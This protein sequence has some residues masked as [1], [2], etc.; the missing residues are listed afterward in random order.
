MSI[1]AVLTLGI[2]Y[3]KE[4]KH[5]LQFN[6]QMLN[7]KWVNIWSGV[8]AMPV[9]GSNNF[10]FLNELEIGTCKF[11]TACDQHCNKT[12]PSLG[13]EASSPGTS[14]QVN[15]QLRHMTHIWDQCLEPQQHIILRRSIGQVNHQGSLPRLAHYYGVL[16]IQQEQDAAGQG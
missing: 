13:P 14:R 11:D 16:C 4:A 3:L 1:F 8:I 10:I 15:Q 7:I 9:T 12:V 5:K 6:M 2:Q